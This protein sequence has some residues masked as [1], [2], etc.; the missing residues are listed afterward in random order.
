MHKKGQGHVWIN[1]NQEDSVLICT[2]TDD[3]IGRKKAAELK[4]KS[5]S[6][7]KS[8][9]MRITT[10]RIALLQRQ[11]QLRTSI[12][13]NDLVN[14]DGSAAGTEVILKIPVMYD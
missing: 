6:L 10:D 1:I 14:D 12:T 3:G 9:G 11:K 8:M 13:V 4:S 5:A 7:H 2:I